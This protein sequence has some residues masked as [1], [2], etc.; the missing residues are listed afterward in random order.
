MKATAQLEIQH[1]IDGEADYCFRLRYAKNKE[2]EV[3]ISID[4]VVAIVVSDLI[5]TYACSG[6][7]P[8]TSAAI[9]CLAKV[10]GEWGTAGTYE[11]IMELMRNARGNYDTI[12]VEEK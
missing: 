10:Y 12:A 2:M 6:A 9:E 8:D 4:D 1:D 5:E 3:P 11:E 7:E